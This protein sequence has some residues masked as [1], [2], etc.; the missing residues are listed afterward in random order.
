MIYLTLLDSTMN[1][2]LSHSERFFAFRFRHLL[3]GAR[4]NFLE[5]TKADEEVVHD[6][7]VVFIVLRAFSLKE[8][9]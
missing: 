7:L 1:L 4:G 8:K 3:W 5:D 6:H 9:L 2:C